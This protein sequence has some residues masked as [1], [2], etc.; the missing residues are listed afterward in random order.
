VE[1]EGEREENLIEVHGGWRIM[2][3][4]VCFILCHDIL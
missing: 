4:K 3:G 1:V 2:T